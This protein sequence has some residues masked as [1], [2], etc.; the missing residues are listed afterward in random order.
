[1][2]LL[3]QVVA[4]RERRELGLPQ[5]LVH[6]GTPDPGDRALVAEQRVEVARLVDQ[7]R[8]LLERRSRPGLWA[9]RG[10]G[11]VFVHRRR[12]QQLAPRALLR[13]ELAQPELA[14][15]VDPEQDA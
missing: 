13:A 1:H 15:V 3:V 8:E 5:D 4:L 11:L 6:P 2:L 10:H 12:S 9:E 14:A 7:L